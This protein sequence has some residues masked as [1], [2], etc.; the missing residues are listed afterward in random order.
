MAL[1]YKPEDS[2]FRPARSEPELVR[3]RT[4]TYKT[5]QDFAFQLRSAQEWIRFRE[6]DD[7]GAGG[8]SVGGKDA[9]ALA[10]DA[11]KND[12]KNKFIPAPSDSALAS[13]PC[14]ICQEKFEMSWKEE[15]QD[16]VWMD[17]IKI[18][19]RVYHASCYADYKKDEDNAP[20]RMAT[21]DSV[22]GKRK[23]EVTCHDILPSLCC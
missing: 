19:G 15:L 6:D 17:A 5:L 3:R 16:F 8:S 23:A 11:A 2:G 7:E 1:P 4:G 20:A 13:M 14:A 18:G 22:L 9:R 12:P 21:P 10:A